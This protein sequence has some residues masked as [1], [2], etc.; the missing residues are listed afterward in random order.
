MIANYL[1][2]KA[3]IELWDEPTDLKW[4]YIKERAKRLKK[5]DPGLRL[6]LFAEGGPYNFW[7]KETDQ[8]G[9]NKLI[10]MWAPINCVES[11]ETQGKGGEIWAYFATL[12]RESAPNFYIDCPA[13]YQRSIA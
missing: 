4:P 10:D 3:L 9:L 8:Y 1:Y 13:I 12:A 6:Q 5:I 7:E 2:I 11:T